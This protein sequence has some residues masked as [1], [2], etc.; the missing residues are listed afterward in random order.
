MI[1]LSST[2]IS[3]MA[4][5]GVLRRRST[6]TSGGLDYYWSSYAGAGPNSSSSSLAISPSPSSNFALS[7]AASSPVTATAPT[8]SKSRSSMNLREAEKSEE[9]SDTIPVPRQQSAGY[10]SQFRAGQ[11]SG[12]SSRNIS[13][14]SLQPDPTSDAESD[15]HRGWSGDSDYSSE[16]MRNNGRTGSD[17]GSSFSAASPLDYR[18]FLTDHNEARRGLLDRSSEGTEREERGD[19]W[20]RESITS[21]TSQMTQTTYRPSARG[22]DED[23]DA[24]S[25][26]MT[27]VP[28]A[29][30]DRMDRTVPAAMV[31]DRTPRQDYPTRLLS[32]TKRSTPTRPLASPSAA[33]YTPTSGRIPFTSPDA[34]RTSPTYGVEVTIPSPQSAPA[35]K[36]EFGEIRLE[37]EEDPVTIKARGQRTTL[38][39]TTSTSSGALVGAMLSSERDMLSPQSVK[40]VRDATPERR[41]REA[42]PGRSPEPPPRSSLRAA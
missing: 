23:D 18:T 25:Q 30:V 27:P 15:S 8:A 12:S 14:K 7:A 42:S 3:P 16:D 41:S 20:V 10:F 29:F 35:W 38:P 1:G 6:D 32:P 11:A 22:D 26:E 33:G 9:M 4:H 5:P 17:S 28:N 13:P 21:Q 34:Q 31:L 24:S 36:S 19:R 2:S 40:K 37:E 39:A